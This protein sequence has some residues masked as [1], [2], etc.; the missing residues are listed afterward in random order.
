MQLYCMISYHEF[1]CDDLDNIP[2]S[3]VICS[4]VKLYTTSKMMIYYHQQSEDDLYVR[5]ACQMSF[6]FMRPKV[7]IR[8]FVNILRTEII[9]R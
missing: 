9:C 4:M 2:I 8:H 5:K 7:K 3:N 1:M 6:L